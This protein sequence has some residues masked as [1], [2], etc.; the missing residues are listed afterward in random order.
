MTKCDI[1]GLRRARKEIEIVGAKLNVCR[2]CSQVRRRP[3]AWL[4]KRRMPEHTV[5]VELRILI[6]RLERSISGGGGG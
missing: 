1:C 6:K 2:T 3:L 4:M 5:R